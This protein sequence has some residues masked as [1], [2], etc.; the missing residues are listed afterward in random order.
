M[1]LKGD[2]CKI[3]RAIKLNSIDAIITDPPY[4]I[5]FMS[6]E[7]DKQHN[8][9]EGKNEGHSQSSDKN[10]DNDCLFSSSSY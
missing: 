8:G 4:L 2:C 9:L 10:R 7:F 5:S 6:K 1:L 3:L